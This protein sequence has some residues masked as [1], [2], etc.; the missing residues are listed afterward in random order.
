[1]TANRVWV[2]E[3]LNSCGRWVIWFAHRDRA[4]V[5]ES[6]RDGRARYPK[7]KFRTVAYVL[8]RGTV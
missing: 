8:R 7:D 3:T 2:C 5:W 6:M 1:M 4:R